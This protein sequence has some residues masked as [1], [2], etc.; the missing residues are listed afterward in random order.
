MNEIKTLIIVESP[1]DEAFIRLLLNNLSLSTVEVEPIE[2]IGIENLHKIEGT[3]IRGKSA[4]DEKIDRLRGQLRIEKYSKVEHISIILDSDSAPSGGV[5]KSIELV[6]NA[7]GFRLGEFPNF[8]NEAEQK[9]ITA[10]ISGEL[11]P[12]TVSCFFIKMENGE[13]HL[14]MV[15]KAIAKKGG[16]V[17]YCVCMEEQ[18]QP[19]M[20]AKGKPI[21]DFEKQWVNYYLRHFATKNC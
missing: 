3:D 12:L 17:E 1:N 8:T 5:Q 7:F 6:N 21:K 14:D 18:L 16:E 19:C 10:N 9:N 13:G 2:T 20:T 15:L 4:L 11:I